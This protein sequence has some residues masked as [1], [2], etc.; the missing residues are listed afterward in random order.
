MYMRVCNKILIFQKTM[1]SIIADSGANFHLF[2]EHK[3][4]KPLHLIPDV[5]FWAMLILPWI[6]WALALLDVLLV[7]TFYA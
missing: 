2:H 4:L 3:F 1:F 6:L 7:P 5:L